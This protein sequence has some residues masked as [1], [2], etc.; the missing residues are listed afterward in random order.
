KM[1]EE[2]GA[3]VERAALS[4]LEEWTDCGL[5][6]Q[7][8][9]Q[10]QV[11]A[12]WL[13][14]RA[15][16]YSAMAREKLLAGKEIAL[17]KV[18]AAERRREALRAEFNALMQSYD[19]LVTLSSSQLPCE[20]DDIEAV[21]R[22]YSSQ[23]RMPFNVTGTPCISIPTGFTRDGLPTAIQIAGRANDEATVYRIAKAYE[24]ATRWGARH[25]DL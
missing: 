24:D 17:D 22:T 11:H 19:A 21:R 16:H 15:Q 5:T 6:I 8:Y 2:L 12:E 1:L 3:R 4:P 18:Q 7:T 13:R 9:E 23:A 20:V 10:Y 25:P 14:T